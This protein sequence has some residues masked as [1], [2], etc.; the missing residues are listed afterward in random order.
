MDDSQPRS[1]RARNRLWRSRYVLRRASEF[2]TRGLLDEADAF[3]KEATHREPNFADAHAVRGLI[4]L[5][6]Y[7]NEG[8]I[9]ALSKAIQLDPTKPNVYYNR[10]LA[11][12]RLGIRLLELNG[13]E[14][15]D[16]ALGV[17]QHAVEDY[18]SAIRLDKF[19]SE[20]YANRAGCYAR[21]RKMKQAGKDMNL[22][23]Q[24][25]DPGSRLHEVHGESSEP[26]KISVPGKKPSVG[27]EKTR[28]SRRNSRKEGF[29]GEQNVGR[30]KTQDGGAHSKTDSLGKQKASATVTRSASAAA[31]TYSDSE[32]NEL[33][34]VNDGLEKMSDFE[35][36]RRERFQ[37]LRQR[38]MSIEGSTD[39]ARL[40]KDR[41]QVRLKLGETAAAAQDEER[42]IKIAEGK[43]TNDSN[44]KKTKAKKKL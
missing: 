33:A 12:Q 40:L 34:F 32:D 18:T 37:Q 26:Q 39:L 9:A 36:K 21:M 27:E 2:L 29:K 41:S 42:A 35:R 10:A 3:L 19:L 1:E 28:N 44:K 22:T 7:K 43:H 24:L 30:G 17:L 8:A 23:I 16:E 14:I 6:T 25:M 13:Q 15:D 38:A 5:K 31:G 20:A 4:L 11:Y